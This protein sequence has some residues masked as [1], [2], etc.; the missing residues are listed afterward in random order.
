MHLA[1]ER[2]DHVRL[3]SFLSG[4]VDA[5]D[6]E[7][8]TAL[9]LAAINGH[10]RCVNMLL[11]AGADVNMVANEH[12]PIMIASLSGHLD[13]VN[14][15]I[16]ARAD[17]NIVTENGRIPLHFA[18]GDPKNHPIVAAFLAAGALVDAPGV[19]ISPLTVA[20][21]SN[22]IESMKLLI[23]AGADVNSRDFETK[24]LG[25]A[26]NY[27]NLAAAKLLL[28][29]KA[30]VKSVEGFESSLFRAASNGNVEMTKLFISA[31]ADVNM[32]HS[33][34]ALGGCLHQMAACGLPDGKWTRERLSGKLDTA[35][36]D[37]PGVLQVL[38]DAKADASARTSY[39]ITPLFA[40]AGKNNVEAVNALIAAG[41]NVNDVDDIGRTPL[42]IATATDN[43]GVVTSLIAAGADLEQVGNNGITALLYAVDHENVSV[44]SALVDAGANVNYCN[45]RE[46]MSVLDFAESIE[47]HDMSAILKKAGAKTLQ[48][49]MVATSDLVRA[50]S[51]GDMEL[52]NKLVGSAGEEEK[53]TALSIAVFEGMFSIVKCL[54]AGG[55]DPETKYG[56]MSMLIVASIVGYADVVRELLDAGADFAAKDD[57][58]RT[59]LQHAAKEKHRDVVALLLAHANKLKRAN[60]LSS[61]Y[62][63]FTFTFT[64]N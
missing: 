31:G 28:D 55:A 24:P 50:V 36:I 2:G 32:H 53:N 22:S 18:C 30:D 29:S 64:F 52:V 23:A 21:K 10:L 45:M 43:L 4:N 42:I 13:V 15:L 11:D 40:A 33:N 17:V 26:T 48:E 57:D 58:G 39:G 12:T 62:A 44:V 61:S 6:E 20:I 16:K 54:L 8:W 34:G 49:L 27:D 51:N 60:K 14:A 59:A 56:S 47:S 37:Y 7:G 5:R 41:T 9:F 3:R 25:I 63:R 46:N 38:I 1:A 35:P 19:E